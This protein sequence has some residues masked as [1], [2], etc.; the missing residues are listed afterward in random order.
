MI[1]TVN[2]HAIHSPYRTTPGGSIESFP[3]KAPSIPFGS[4]HTRFLEVLIM[5]KATIIQA[6]MSTH[7]G[8]ASQSSSVL[9]KVS[10]LCWACIELKNA[11]P[12]TGGRI[13]EAP[14]CSGCFFRTLDNF[15]GR[16]PFSISNDR[17]PRVKAR[18]HEKTCRGEKNG[19]Y[20]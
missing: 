9:V 10:E 2:F 11:L 13:L 5:N 3:G 8:K 12:I 19:L 16:C 1:A 6:T 17:I 20:H 15:F 7:A 4:I 18:L 14:L